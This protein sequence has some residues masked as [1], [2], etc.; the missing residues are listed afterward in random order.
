MI[1]TRMVQVTVLTAHSFVQCFK[2]QSIITLKVLHDN[3]L[4]P[5]FCLRKEV[6]CVVRK[7]LR[8]W[9]EN[10]PGENIANLQVLTYQHELVS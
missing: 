2:A 1:H 8:R 10:K 9:S 6:N 4:R 7:K 5:C 3:S